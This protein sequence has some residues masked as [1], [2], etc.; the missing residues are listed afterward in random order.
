MT[1][2]AIVY[3]DKGKAAIHDVPIPKLREDYVLVKVN[4]VGL[5]PTDWKHID[6]GNTDPGSRVGCDYAGIV[7]AVGPKVQ[8]EFRKGDRISGVVH[9]SDRTQHENGAFANYI[10]AKGDV[11]IKTPDNISDEDAAT[12]GI[13]VATVGQ[14]LY[15]TLG[16]PLPTG[17]VK[18]ASDEYVL[19]HGG[20]TA[21]GIY[22]IQYARLSGLK[23]IAT[24]SPHNFEYLKSLGAEE[25]FDY[26][27]PTAGP[28]I[29]KYT[30]NGL[31]L[32]WDCTG[33]GGSIIAAALSSEGGKYAAIMPVNKE[34]VD[35]INPNIDGPHMTFMYTI[36]GERF[37]KKSETPPKPEEFEFA[38]MFWELSR[39][40]LADGKLKAPR[41]IVNRG[42]DGFEGILKGLDELRANKV[43]GGKLV[44]TL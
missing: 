43:S 11:Q 4:A 31:K 7:E 2:K 6:F 1:T 23:V 10:V 16:L 12:L 38:K 32:A 9:G 26:K 19:I 8:K 36:F 15:K 17:D 13:S 14:G 29:R 44:Y 21:T 18:K 25:I 40:L 41:T 24:A 22:G 39:G 5:N 35:A 37:V 30:K 20:S 27:S 42:G 3:V 28:D 34:E 33:S